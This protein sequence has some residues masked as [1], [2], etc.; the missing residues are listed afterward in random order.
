MWPLIVFASSVAFF[1]LRKRYQAPIQ[2]QIHEPAVE[3]LRETSASC[4][5]KKA[6]CIGINYTGTRHELK[7]CINDARCMKTFLTKHYGYEDNR[8][9]I[10]ADTPGHIYPTK[11][12]IMNSI[13]W[14]I[15]GCKPGDSLFFSYSGHGT[16]VRD[17]NGDEIDGQDEALCTLDG[18]VILDDWLQSELMSKIP[19]GVKLTCVFDCCHSGTIADLKYCYRTNP[20][21]Q[22]FSMTIERER[23]LDSDITVFSACL[24]PQ[25]AADSNF[26]GKWVMTSDG[27]MTV[28]WGEGNGAFTWFFLKAIENNKFKITNDELLKQTVSMLKAHKFTQIAHFTCTNSELFTKGFEL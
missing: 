11:Q 24:D 17:A 23:D 14:L 15:S 2:E 16:F 27:K 19:K 4:P 13:A 20:D 18:S 22:S 6:L 8:V 25:T 1:A 7:G 5:N 9:L 28:E 12:N 26:N 3:T 21:A 10:L